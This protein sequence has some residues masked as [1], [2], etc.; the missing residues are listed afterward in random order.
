M[1]SASE[2]LLNVIGMNKKDNLM[3]A[4]LIICV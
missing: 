3:F 1:I 4:L 2:I